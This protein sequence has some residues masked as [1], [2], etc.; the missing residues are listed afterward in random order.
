METL[1]II[2]LIALASLTYAA[3][4]YLER[5]RSEER[6]KNSVIRERESIASRMLF[7]YCRKLLLNTERNY[8][9]KDEVL[10]HLVAVLNVQGYD[11]RPATTP[12]ES[13]PRD[14]EDEETGGALS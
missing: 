10:G 5:E 8:I 3:L 2:I 7:G 4:I 6:A 1:P 11:P 13:Q 14:E 12:Q 9:D